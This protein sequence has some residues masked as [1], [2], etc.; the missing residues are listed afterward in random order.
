MGKHEPLRNK[1]RVEEGMYQHLPDW[2]PYVDVKDA[3]DGMKEEIVIS[4]KDIIKTI[5]KW[6]YDVTKDE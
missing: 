2:F 3:V 4:G 1:I 5:N 6:M